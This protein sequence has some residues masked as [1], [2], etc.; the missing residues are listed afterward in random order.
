M[1]RR[2]TRSISRS[3]CRGCRVSCKVVRIIG[4]PGV[5]IALKV[6]EKQGRVIPYRKAS[7]PDDR[8]G[9]EILLRRILSRRPAAG[10]SRPHPASAASRETCR[11]FR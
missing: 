2:P 6:I 4:Q 1:P 7:L 10:G 8:A 9:L 11:E 5:D 3:T